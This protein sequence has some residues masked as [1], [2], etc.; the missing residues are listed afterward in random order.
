MFQLSLGEFFD[1]FFFWE[2]LLDFG[3][4][5]KLSQMADPFVTRVVQK[6]DTKISV[7]TSDRRMHRLWSRS[8]FPTNT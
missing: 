1:V 4:G 7:V 6:F 2:D 8:V 3:N 5:A